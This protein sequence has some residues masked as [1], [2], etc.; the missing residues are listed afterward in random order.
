M[1]LLIA[2]M[3]WGLDSV[4][5]PLIMSASVWLSTMIFMQ[6]VFSVCGLHSSSFPSE[7]RL[8]LSSSS[9]V[10]SV[11]RACFCSLRCDDADVFGF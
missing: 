9:R 10:A 2:G 11:S 4:E 1:I 6:C 7:V 3:S 8:M 5:S